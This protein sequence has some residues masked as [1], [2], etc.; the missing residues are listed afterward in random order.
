MLLKDS[1]PLSAQFRRLLQ[2]SRQIPF[3]RFMQTALYDPRNGYYTSGRVGIGQAKDFITVASETEM[4]GASIAKAAAKIWHGLGRPRNFVVL[5]QGAGNGDLARGF[6]TR[7]RQIDPAFAEQIRYRIAE[8]SPAL[9]NRQR[10]NLGGLANEVHWSKHSARPPSSAKFT[11]LIVSNELPDAFPVER[12]RFSTSQQKFLQCYVTLINNKWVEVWDLPQPEVAS[13]LERHRIS[14]TKLSGEIAVNTRAEKWMAR[15]TSILDR[16]AILTFDY[17]TRGIPTWNGTSLAVRY[18]GS[19]DGGLTYA[20]ERQDPDHIYS[21]AGFLDIT[22]PVHFGALETVAHNHGY[23]TEYSGTQR[24][25]LRQLGTKEIASLYQDDVRNS[26]S[27]DQVVR[28]SQALFGFRYE[29]LDHMGNY[30][31][32]MLTRGLSR[33]FE[34]REQLKQSPDSSAQSIPNQ[35]DSIERRFRVGAPGAVINVLGIPRMYQSEHFRNEFSEFPDY[36]MTADTTGSIA[37]PPHLLTKVVLSDV[38]GRAISDPGNP[39]QFHEFLR[40]SGFSV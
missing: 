36:L 3:S 20:G 25:F 31:S 27:W 35:S 37:L 2:S 10:Y 14:G 19:V 26:N 23:V 5:E 40:S 13:Y 34:W 16:G 8:I 11:G 33:T 39:K 38:N 17:G 6:L 21:H 4:F 22:S 12:V 30:Y 9:V 7:V 32:S 1:L 29:A 15:C 28:A 24:N 18:F